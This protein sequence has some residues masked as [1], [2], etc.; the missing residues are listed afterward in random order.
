[1][2]LAKLTHRIMPYGSRLPGV[3]WLIC[4][5]ALG[6]ALTTRFGGR[7]DRFPTIRQK[8]YDRKI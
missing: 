6:K 7:Y 3:P 2:I 5:V 8:N 1:L 4:P